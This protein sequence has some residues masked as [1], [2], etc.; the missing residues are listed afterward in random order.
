MPS[1]AKGSKVGKNTAAT[2]VA[3]AA[4]ATA[5]D[6]MTTPGASTEDA[7]LVPVADEEE[8]TRL[9]MDDRPLEPPSL[10]ADK[11]NWLAFVLTNVMEDGLESYSPLS[12]TVST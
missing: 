3:V 2:M 5:S 8:P 1:A 12:P 11:L 7:E 6:P 10:P 9:L 4:M